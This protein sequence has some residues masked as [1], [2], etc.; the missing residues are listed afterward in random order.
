LRP[1]LMTTLTIVIGL[2]P[3]A[4]ASGA[5]SEWKNGLAWAL[6]GGLSSS[7]VLTLIVIPVIYYS[8][9]KFLIRFGWSE[10]TRKKIKLD[11]Y[12]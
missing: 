10:M 12:D 6:I 1:V 3:V 7:L 9:E 8:I 11:D 4:L 5:G 2:L